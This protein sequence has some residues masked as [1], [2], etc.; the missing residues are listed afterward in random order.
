M[1]NIAKTDK[2]DIITEIFKSKIILVGSPTIGKGITSATAAILEEIKGL[3]FKNKKA[4]AFGCYGWSG[5]SIS[6]INSL[7][8][9]SGFLLVNQGI[10]CL[11]NPDDK[12]IE[13][14]IEFGVD[15]SR[16]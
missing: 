13:K 10:K 9:K 14:C 2:N 1:F 4:A 5:E 16:S 8:E 3:R 15:I 11:W 7:L 12:S 6:K